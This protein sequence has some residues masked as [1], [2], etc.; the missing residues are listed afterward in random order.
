[1]LHANMLAHYAVICIYCLM[2]SAQLIYPRCPFQI[3]YGVLSTSQG[4]ANRA[5]GRSKNSK[6]I[7]L[8]SSDTR[9][10]EIEAWKFFDRCVFDLAP[11]SIQESN[12]SNARFDSA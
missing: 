10:R 1:M 11:G 3:V 7:P 2:R 5:L 4:A 6:N 9:A 12:L 8:F